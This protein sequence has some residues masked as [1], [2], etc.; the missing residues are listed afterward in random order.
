MLGSLLPWVYWLQQT[1]KTQ[2]RELK[3]RYQLAADAAAQQFV[4][5]PLTQSM[6]ADDRRTWIEWVRWMANNYQQPRSLK[7]FQNKVFKNIQLPKETC[8]MSGKSKTATLLNC[9]SPKPG[10]A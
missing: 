4:T 3:A 8:E 7:A 1:G 5:Y 10:A 6:S 9:L 2:H